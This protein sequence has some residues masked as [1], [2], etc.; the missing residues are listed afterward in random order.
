[1]QL[2]GCDV[3][4]ELQR[5]VGDDDTRSTLP[6]RSPMPLIVPCTCVAPSRTAARVLATARSQS[7]W[8]WMPSGDRRRAAGP[9]AT[10]SATSVGQAAAVGVA[11][12]EPAAR[13]RRSA[14]WSVCSA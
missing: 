14:A 6:Q 12:H 7:L 2:A 10:I 3:E 11:E 4:P 5:E 9:R 1:M 8:V 13:P